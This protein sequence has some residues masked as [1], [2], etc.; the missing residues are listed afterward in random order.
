M[1]RTRST[2]SML[3]AAAAAFAF[4]LAGLGAQSRAYDTDP[5]SVRGANGA[6]GADLNLA[7]FAAAD[8]NDDNQ[9]TRAELKAA[10]A[11]FVAAADTAKTGAVTA[12]QLQAG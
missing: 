9:V 2:V 8:S 7:F 6:S 3:A 10:I 12:D 11:R 5:N 1:I 4:G